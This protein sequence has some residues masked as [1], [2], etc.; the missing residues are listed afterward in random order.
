M[1]VVWMEEVTRFWRL[2]EIDTDEQVSD[3]GTC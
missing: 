1:K 3:E 2:E